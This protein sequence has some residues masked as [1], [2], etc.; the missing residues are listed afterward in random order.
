[1][2]EAASRERIAVPPLSAFRLRP[3]EAGGLV[4]GYGRLHESAV[5]EATRALAAVVRRRL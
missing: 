5:A 3:A 2:A 1:V 4:I